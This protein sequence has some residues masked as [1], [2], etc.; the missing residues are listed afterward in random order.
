[1]KKHGQAKLVLNKGEHGICR[2]KISSKA[3]SVVERLQKFGY[4]AYLVG[5][6][7]RDL[8]S[9]KD[10]KDFDV[11]TNA[12]PEQ[13]RR[14]F[15]NSRI[16]GRRFKIVHVVFGKEIIEV[17]TFR[18]GSDTNKAKAKAA[19]QNLRV[20]S[21]SGML[22]RDNVYGKDISEDA[23][24]RD[25]TI[26]AIYYDSQKETLL[27]FHGGLYDLMTGVIDIIGDPK[28]RYLEDPVRIIRALRF[29]AKLGFKISKRTTSPIKEMS[30]NL[31]EVSNARMFE[32][33]NKLFLTGHGL[34]SF[35]ILRKYHIFEVLFPSLE[36]F[37]DN[38]VFIDFIE[39]ALNSSDL[40][41]HNNKRN[42][43]HFLYAVLLWTRFQSLV[44]KLQQNNDCSPVPLSTRKIVNIA[45]PKVI[46]E[47]TVM[48]AI[49]MMFTENIRSLWVNQFMLLNTEDDEIVRKITAT[50]MFRAA[51]DF[52]SLR[53]R[54]EPYLTSYVEFWKPFYD[55]SA[56]KAQEKREISARSFK[57]NQKIRER[58]AKKELKHTNLAEQTFE[59]EQ[60]KE[61]ND[62]LAKARAWRIAMHLDP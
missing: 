38:Q 54:F 39:Y 51:Y 10:P 45:F 36:E 46:G 6:C 32:E 7:I 44:Y 37:L 20:S 28:T 57:E 59:K 4:K 55:E 12:T 61:V 53:A 15:A 21:G 24:R 58:Q 35:K 14:V 42:T 31:K 40:R 2:E 22:V 41:Y 34:E 27:D 19:A 1:M 47:Q 62:R 52:L 56:R 25:F 5:G 33:V 50:T 17:T 60:S 13:V 9:G 11:S 49:P 23:S 48:T 18:G 8:L 26:N 16:I 3:L 30:Q 29:C 43:P